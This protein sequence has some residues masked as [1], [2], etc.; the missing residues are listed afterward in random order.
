MSRDLIQVLSARL[1]TKLRTSSQQLALAESCTGGLLA[2]KIVEQAGASDIFG[3]GVVSYSNEAKEKLLNVRADLINE[4]GAVSAQVA[5]AMAQGAL[6]RSG[7]DLALSITGIAGP[8][9][10]TDAKPVGLVYFGLAGQRPRAYAER[11]IFANRGRNYIQQQAILYALRWL[12][13]TASCPYS[14]LNRHASHP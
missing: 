3:F 8:S 14:R 13:Q 1:V 10:G 2:A 9:G 5:A 6:Q 12:N 4:H 7:A 11:K